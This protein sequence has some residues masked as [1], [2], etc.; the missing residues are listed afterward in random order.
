MTTLDLSN[1]GLTVLPDFSLYPNITVLNLNDNA[2]T[3]EGIFPETL[4]ELYIRNNSFSS[5]VLPP[6][7]TVLD[8]YENQIT[9]PTITALPPLLKNIRI[10]FVDI[11]DI[12][13]LPPCILELSNQPNMNLAVDFCSDCI[14]IEVF[15]S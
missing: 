5:I 4:T 13:D 6:L 14:E 12:N 2:I 1:Q 10:T 3:G 15:P 7:L 8:A 9:A 11:R